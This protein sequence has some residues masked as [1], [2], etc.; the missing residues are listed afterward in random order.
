MVGEG[1]EGQLP[2]TVLGSSPATCVRPPVPYDTDPHNHP[3]NLLRRLGNHL[4][5][6]FG[7]NPGDSWLLRQARM[8]WQGMGVVFASQARDGAIAETSQ[9]ARSPLLLSWGPS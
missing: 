3:G 4:L 2:D 5:H 1:E 8:A 9:K 6:Q 7:G